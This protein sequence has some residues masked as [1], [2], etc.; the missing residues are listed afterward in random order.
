MKLTE[1]LSD[2][3]E[4]SAV[5]QE[6]NFASRSALIETDWRPEIAPLDLSLRGYQL[7]ATETILQYRRGILGLQPGLGKTICALT[8]VA[9]DGGKTVAVVPPSLKMIWEME[10]ARCFPGLRVVSI[11]GKKA[12]AI[13]DGDLLLVGDSIVANRTKD[14]EAWG[15]A[16]LIIDEA[17][18]HKNRT[19]KRAK[20]VSGL[21]DKIRLQ[22]GIV[23][24]LTGTLA[25]NRADE[26]WMPASIAG[27]ANKICRDGSYKTWINTW[28]YVD[29]MPV[30]QKRGKQRRTIWIEVPKGSKNPEGLNK[31][32]C[33]TGY[34]RVERED[35][36]DLPD[37]VYAYRTLAGESDGMKE[38]ARIRDDFEK[39]LEDQG[40]VEA[41][42]KASG[43][44][45]LVQLGKL[46]EYAGLARLKT[47]AEYIS[48]LVEEGEPVVVMAHHK[49]VVRGTQAALAELGIKSVL[50]YGEMNDAEKQ[51]SYRSF[52]AGEVPVFIGNI[53]S[54][55]TGLNLEN[56]AEL[57]FVQ[58]PWSPGD[59][60]QAADRIYR[61]T[62]ERKCT[63]HVL[64][65][66]QT[67]DTYVS[68][69]LSQ[70]TKVVDAINAG[71]PMEMPDESTVVDEVLEA[72]Y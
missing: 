11:S 47:S 4:K 64:S 20:A 43:A 14:I 5:E 44:M 61:V 12:C 58:L 2:I 69:V 53:T 46:V 6:D 28:S 55:G 33:A 30:E 42:E 23:C 38:Y 71:K 52:K 40:G 18:R 15:P 49:S 67:I 36:L 29:S 1:L 26:V 19:A 7:A 70:K 56:S 10:A 57:V 9:N 13:E 62:Q 24:L 59:F 25:V 8:A 16:N 34:I 50:F 3:E 68:K 54:A 31:A 22:D 48:T 21:A 17:Q 27:I 45:K 35:A 51:E 37:K 39:W 41:V 60:V 63:I 65:T 32:L 66:A 72:M